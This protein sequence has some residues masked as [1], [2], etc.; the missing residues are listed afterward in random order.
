MIEQQKQL[1]TEF[2][3]YLKEIRRNINRY[4][5]IETKIPTIGLT[6]ELWNADYYI[7]YC[8]GWRLGDQ[9]TDKATLI[10]WFREMLKI[11][12]CKIILL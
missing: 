1:R 5:C 2:E 8:D 7:D 4:I 12:E 6:G 10:K 11:T 9:Y 3:Q